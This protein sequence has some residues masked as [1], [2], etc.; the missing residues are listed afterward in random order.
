MQ[1][2]A[3]PAA[4]AAVDR[5]KPAMPERGS[6]LEV[7][8]IFLRLGLTSFGGPVAHLGYYRAEFVERRKWLD[9]H[10]Y[11]DIV[12]LW[13]FLPGP[14]SSQVG[15]TVGI[16]R[17]GFLG[18]L[19]AWIGF[20]MP[21]AAAMILFGYGLTRFGDL[22]GAPWLHGLKIVAVA[23]VAQA[24]W[25]MAQSLRPAAAK[26]L[27]IWATIAVGAAILAL[28]V[29]SA[30]GQ[31]VAIL[32]GALI[33]WALLGSAQTPPS[34]VSIAVHIPRALSVAAAILFVALLFGLPLLAAAVPAQPI[35]LLDSFYRS[36]SLVFGG[37]HVVL[38]LL[39]A[40]VVPSGWVS[41]DAFL[42]GY[43][44]AQAVP[45]PLFTFAA[46][47]GTV[48]GPAPNGVIGGLLCLAAIFLPSFL[49]LIGALPFWDSLR[50]HPVVQSALPGVN[51]A[52]VGLLLA[53]LYRPVWTS[54]IFAP[55]DFAIGVVAFL[56]LT[57]WAVPPWLVVI[58]GALG[59]SAVA[60]VV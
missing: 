48:M 8:R 52:V 56:M 13:Q 9:E 30:V 51:A 37:G 20:T 6:A 39:Q 26:P 38:P 4:I 35:K 10:T 36:G 28:A 60:A 16:M 59:A 53:A 25:G 7:L 33:G 11:A 23:V 50:R 40:E 12:A 3:E 41:N 42:A 2:A 19:A 34:G 15:I 24:V 29:P 46:Y 21:S 47:L 18:A 17:A 54:A 31:V 44:A 45:G 43:G 5:P 22:S 55:Q 14:T 32:A 57:F 49:L 27:K 58:L 1:G